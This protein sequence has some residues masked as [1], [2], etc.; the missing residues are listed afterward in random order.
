MLRNWAGQPE[1]A[2]MCLERAQK[3]APRGRIGY[4]LPSRALAH[5]VLRRF[6][7]AI[8]DALLAIQEDPA[9]PSSYRIL[10]ASYALAGRLNEA[11]A[12]IKQLRAV[13]P[14]P[15]ALSIPDAWRDC[16]Q[17]E[18]FLSGLRMAV[19]EEA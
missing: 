19:T 11:R 10:A 16:E 8:R 18:L 12:T 13:A 5:C 7:E 15:A 14:S 9:H 4:L 17:R 6:E 1:E 2:L 3:L